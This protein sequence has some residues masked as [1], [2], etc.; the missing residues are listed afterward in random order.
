MLRGLFDVSGLTTPT[1]LC[2]ILAG[3]IGLSAD[4]VFTFGYL[5]YDVPNISWSAKEGGN[6]YFFGLEAGIVVRAEW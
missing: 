6:N 5:R 2:L 4:A 1:F 3:S